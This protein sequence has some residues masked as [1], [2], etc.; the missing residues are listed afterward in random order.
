MTEKTF[1]EEEFESV[2]SKAE[3][4]YK[5]IANVQCPYLESKV[6]F[7]TMGLDHNKAQAME[8]RER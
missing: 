5:K 4:D 2:K 8:S 3:E 7:N 6:Q 1:T